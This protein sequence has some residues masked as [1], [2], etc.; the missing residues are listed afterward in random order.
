MLRPFLI[1]AFLLL[2]IPAYAQ[3]EAAPSDALDNLFAQ[4]AQEDV[5]DEAAE[6]R[7]PVRD[8]IRERFQKRMAKLN[9]G[10]LKKFDI[11]G[12]SVAYWMPPVVPGEGVLAKPLVIFSHGFHGCAGQ[13]IFLMKALAAAG[14]IVV[15]PEHADSSC[16]TGSDGIA[17]PAERFADYAAWTDKTYA[18]RAT[19]IKNLYAAL[20]ADETWN[21]RIDWNK[22][23]LAGHSLG[24]YT[25]L[26]LA[27]AWKVWKMEGIKAVLALSP[28][29]GPFIDHGDLGTLTVP[30]MYQGGTRDF[31]ITPSVRKKGGAFEQTAAPAWFVEFIN[32]GHFSWT[33]R[34]ETTHAPEVKERI[35]KYSLWFLDHALKGA[36]EP[37]PQDKGLA[38][39]GTK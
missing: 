1:I 30:V 39:S 11:V 20:K 15:A 16:W 28:Y 6:S 25:A 8:L 18:D 24:G 2:A 35:V 19:D 12:L 17:K 22:V 33:D 7:G 9:G 23:A 3:T 26:G 14:Y 4:P 27:G 32:A 31:G 36:S 13:S 10:E 29:V 5:S 21:K 38:S 37:F 34:E